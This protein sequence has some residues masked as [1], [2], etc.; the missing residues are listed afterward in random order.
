M[1]LAP[2]LCTYSRLVSLVRILRLPSRSLK[3]GRGILV[4]TKSMD[5]KAASR[6]TTQRLESLSGSK[7]I[8]Q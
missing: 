3:V 5:S 6:S 8:R 4:Q 2:G 1:N 7:R